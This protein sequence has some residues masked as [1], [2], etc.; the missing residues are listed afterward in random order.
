[1]RICENVMGHLNQKGF[2]ST[3]QVNPTAQIYFFICCQLKRNVHLHFICSDLADQWFG[4]VKTI[5]LQRHFNSSLYFV[6]T[7]RFLNN[8]WSL[9]YIF[10]FLGW[11][12]QNVTKMT[13]SCSHLN[14]IWYF[15]GPSLL[16]TSQ[17]ICW[18]PSFFTSCQ[19][20]LSYA[21]WVF[22]PQR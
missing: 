9:S 11:N 2:Y 12:F 19:C 7:V 8:H 17:T 3:L 15:S 14:L 4:S 13:F 16:L 22:S 5:S 6:T 21:T 20:Q 1:M 18:D 10:S